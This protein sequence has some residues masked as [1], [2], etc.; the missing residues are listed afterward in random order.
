MR[1]QLR[2]GQVLQANVTLDWGDLMTYNSDIKGL[3]NAL[4]QIKEKAQKDAQKKKEETISSDIKGLMNALH[5]IKEKAQKD[6]QKKKEET[7]S[8]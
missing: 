1:H 8:R 6:G 4:H 3:M 7:I 2:R 5:Q